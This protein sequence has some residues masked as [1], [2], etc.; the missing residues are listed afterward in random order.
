M[1]L[2]FI[3][4]LEVGQGAANVLR[5]GREKPLGHG[6]TKNLFLGI[7]EITFL[8]KYCKVKFDLFVLYF[9]L[10][11]FSFFICLWL[12]WVFTAAYS[13]SL[14]V[15]IRGYSLAAVCGLLTAAASHVVQP[16]LLDVRSVAGAQG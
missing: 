15:V 4:Q 2:Y 14:A 1:A 7:K 9:T 16:G 13:L 12:C 5:A 6:S 11:N 3:N 8:W 10:F